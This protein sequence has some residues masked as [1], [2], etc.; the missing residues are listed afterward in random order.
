[1]YADSGG[2]PRKGES[3]RCFSRCLLCVSLLIMTL[4]LVF[5]AEPFKVD[6]QTLRWAD[7][8]YGAV[9]RNRLLEWQKF[10]QTQEKED[11]AKLTM[12]NRFIN[13]F[14][15]IDDFFHWE[16]EDYWATPI[17]FIASGGGDCEDFAIAKYFSLITL[18]VSSE[19]LALHYVVSL[20]LNQSH[21]VLAY[22]PAPGGE[23]LILD[24]LVETIKPSSQR[25]DLAPVYSFNAS[26]LW[27]AKHMGRGKVLG[28]SR[29][30][31]QWREFMV[32]MKQKV[33]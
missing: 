16:Q 4:A 3:I 24:N 26:V 21:L 29:R 22:Y 27:E 20:S 19:K 28:D 13:A 5:A 18:G 9:G 25:P 32:R 8:R 17:E 10:L 30:I 31:R 14:T 12:V 15:F 33:H 2:L 23:P 11:M 1:M 7:G 6:E